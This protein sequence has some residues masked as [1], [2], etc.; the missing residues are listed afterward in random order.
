MAELNFVW[1]VGND[2]ESRRILV[3]AYTATDL[4][5][6]RIAVVGKFALLQFCFCPN[7]PMTFSQCNFYVPS[8]NK[9]IVNNLLQV[10]LILKQKVGQE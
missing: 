6:F 10:S 3:W 5:N 8:V 2:L 1:E 9:N 4:Q 7:S